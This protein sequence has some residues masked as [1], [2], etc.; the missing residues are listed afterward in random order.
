MDKLTDTPL[1]RTGSPRENSVDY[2]LFEQ[3]ESE[4]IVKHSATWNLKYRAK[5]FPELKPGDRVWVKAPFDLGSEG[6][7]NRRDHNLN[8]YW[9]IVGAK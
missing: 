8:S 6:V 7:V 4:N 5:H 1:S 2:K 3:I 9:V